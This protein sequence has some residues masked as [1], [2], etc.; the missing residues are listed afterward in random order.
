MWRP[1]T[2][3]E[4]WLRDMAGGFEKVNFAERWPALGDTKS[5]GTG[6]YSE[7]RKRCI[8]SDVVTILSRFLGDKAQLLFSQN[9]VADEPVSRI[10]RAGLQTNKLFG[11]NRL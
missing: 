10:V 3:A 8:T 11:I 6:P 7:H 9:F 2:T 1:G 4:V 5:A